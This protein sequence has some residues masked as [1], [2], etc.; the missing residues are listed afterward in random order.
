MS[1]NGKKEGQVGLVMKGDSKGHVSSKLYSTP[2][3]IINRDSSEILVYKLIKG[4]ERNLTRGIVYTTFDI[5]TLGLSEL[6]TTPIEINRGEVYYFIGKFRNNK[7]EKFEI[8]MN[9]NELNHKI[10]KL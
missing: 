7:L 10:A 6:V 8:A 2:V 3:Q 1:F 5:L 4:K 9:K